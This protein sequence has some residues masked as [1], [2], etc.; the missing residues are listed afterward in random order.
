MSQYPLCTESTSSSYV[1]LL[2]KRIDDDD[3]MTMVRMITMMLAAAPDNGTDGRM[4]TTMLEMT[5]VMVV[6]I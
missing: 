2:E 6:F 1:H 4:M 5:M 3:Y